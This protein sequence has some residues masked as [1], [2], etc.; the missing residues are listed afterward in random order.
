[1]HFYALLALCLFLPRRKG[2]VLLSALILGSIGLQ[3]L[4]EYVTVEPPARVA[5]RMVQ[6]PFFFQNFAGTWLFEEAAGG[7]SRVV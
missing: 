2:L 5:V 1:M 6:G 4:V 3:M 7:S